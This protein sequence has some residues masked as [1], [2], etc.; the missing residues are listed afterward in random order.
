[1][2]SAPPPAP[3]PTQ[4]LL[5]LSVLVMARGGGILPLLLPAGA[6]AP[7]SLIPLGAGLPSGMV[8]PLPMRRWCPAG[9]LPGPA[10]GL[11]LVET[12]TPKCLSARRARVV[13]PTPWL[14]LHRPPPSE[15]HQQGFSSS[16]V[17]CTG[18]CGAVYG[19][20]SSHGAAGHAP[21]VDLDEVRQSGAVRCPVHRE[22]HAHQ[23]VRGGPRQTRGGEEVRGWWPGRWAGT[24]QSAPIPHPG[25]MI[26]PVS[27][28][29]GSPPDGGL[30]ETLG[31]RGSGGGTRCPLQD[32][33][34]RCWVNDAGVVGA[35]VRRKPRT[36]SHT[37]EAHL[38]VVDPTMG[39][40]PQ[41]SYP[42]GKKEG[43]LQGVAYSLTSDELRAF[44]RGSR[45]RH[46]VPPRC[47]RPATGAAHVKLGGR[48]KFSVRWT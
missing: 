33:G 14:K 39:Y 25:G 45:G 16:G 1:M 32:E 38:V 19:S 28:P 11:P 15:G 34:S 12:R 37:C 3:A 4:S 41:G 35:P 43:R 13:T 42:P 8:E 22:V 46:V 20:I 7:P 44:P 31:G 9:W 17:L 2:S 18:E 27:A 5:L 21:W 36:G 40:C 26:I 10:R 6:T 30:A 29:C 48:W 47:G 24:P 23:L